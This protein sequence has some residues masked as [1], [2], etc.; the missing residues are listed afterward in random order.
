MK[1]FFVVNVDWFLFSH[2]LPVVE[3]A[4]RAGYDVHIATTFTDFKY[5]SYLLDR[6]FI[7]HD[8]YIDRKGSNFFSI[9]ATFFRLFVLFKSVS[10]HI[11]HLVTIQ[12]VLLGGLAAR[13]TGVKNVVFAIS[14]FGHSQ[15]ITS[16]YSRLRLVLIQLFYKISLKAPCRVVMFQNPDDMYK[17]KSLCTL[18]DHECHLI[19]GSGVDIAKFAFSPIPYGIPIVFMASRLL[20]TKG[21]RE[22][23]FAEK[24]LR[25]S[26]VKCIFQ[27]AGCP[28]YSNPTS[29]ISSDL[30]ALSLSSNVQFLG[31]RDDLETLMRQ[32]SVVCLPSYYPEGLPKVL[33]EASSCGR[34]IVTTD[35]PGCRDAI[36]PDST[37]ILIPI[38]DSHALAEAINTLL[39]NR[40]LMSNMGIAARK[41]AE[42]YF[43]I[44]II[45]EHH[46]FIYSTLSA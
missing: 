28:D 36:V 42:S 15:I 41:H 17:L 25:E 40:L 3:A 38:R 14:G 39:S 16:L 2:R 44:D 23:I 7:V 10:P 24:L 11:A 8:L 29:L 26:N 34:P 33:C 20:A 35:H 5:K 12:P 27:L 31:H 18:Q 22:F 46:L 6:G 4:L 32:A 43:D 37:G 21:V 19:H 9:I 30:Q 13:L 45:V 1:L